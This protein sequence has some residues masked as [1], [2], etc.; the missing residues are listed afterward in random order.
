M[1]EVNK[2]QRQGKGGGGG[3]GK[4]DIFG[5]IWYCLKAY[6]KKTYGKKT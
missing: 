5:L 2:R 4:N 3:D 6:V 1:P